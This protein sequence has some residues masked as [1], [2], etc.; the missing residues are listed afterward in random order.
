ML[1]AVTDETLRFWKVFAGSEFASGA[2]GTL[3]GSPAGSGSGRR[4]FKCAPADD[5]GVGAGSSSNPP[6]MREGPWVE[7]Q[8]RKSYSICSM[9]SSEMQV[10]LSASLV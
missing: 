3:G 10:I 4:N 5:G 6:P 7:D 8:V 1:L 2:A 9:F